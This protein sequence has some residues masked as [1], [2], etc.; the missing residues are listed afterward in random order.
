M[1]GDKM[2]NLID[3]EG[4]EKAVVGSFEEEVVVVRLQ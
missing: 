4:E 1:V 3:R 2:C